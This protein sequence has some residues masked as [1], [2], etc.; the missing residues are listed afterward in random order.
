MKWKFFL[1]AFILQL[2]LS[3]QNII[4]TTPGNYSDFLLTAANSPNG[5]R[6]AGSNSTYTV[7]LFFH[8]VRNSDGTGGQNLAVLSTIMNNLSTSFSP[9]SVFFNNVGND[10]IRN[11]NY[12][13]NFFNRNDAANSALYNALIGTNTQC[14]ALNV[15]LL[16]DGSR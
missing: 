13:S 8:F 10:E 11:N 6:I 16:A 5:R 4:C 3:A 2:E 15:Y 9:Y 7:N 14:G 12:T 1:V